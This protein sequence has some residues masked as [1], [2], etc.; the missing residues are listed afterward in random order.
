MATWLLLSVLPAQVRVG[1]EWREPVGRA[2]AEAG[3]V[4]S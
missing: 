1:L 4:P 3:G 2:E